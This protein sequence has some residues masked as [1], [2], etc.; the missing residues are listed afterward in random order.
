MIIPPTPIDARLPASIS[1]SPPVVVTVSS[2][3]LSADVVTSHVITPAQKPETAPPM[4]PHLFA[5]LQVMHIAMGTTAE[6]SAT[7]MNSYEGRCQIKGGIL[8]FQ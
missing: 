5:L 2:P 6:P 7:P 3:P 8:L 4:Q 1:K